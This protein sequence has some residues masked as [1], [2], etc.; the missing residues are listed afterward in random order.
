MELPEWIKPENQ[1]EKD[2]LLTIA[3]TFRGNAHEQVRVKKAVSGDTCLLMM[4][5]KDL[6]VWLNWQ[7]IALGLK[8]GWLIKTGI[9]HQ[10][11]MRR[12]VF[13]YT[14]R[15]CLPKSRYARLIRRI[16][17]KFGINCEGPAL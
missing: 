8:K 5:D 15:Y 9:L 3:Q 16:K 12:N 4:F 1:K 17:R 13:A 2:T 14:G 11:N 7:Q 6:Y 10:N